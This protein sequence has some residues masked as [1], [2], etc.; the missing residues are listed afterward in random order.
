MKLKDRVILVTGASKGIGAAIAVEAAREGAGVVVNYLSDA[1]GTDNTVAAIKALGREALGIR[2]DVTK[3]EEIEKMLAEGIRSF[4]KVDLLVN[5]AGI[6]LWKP[7]LESDE[8]NWDC[9]LN[10]K[11]KVFF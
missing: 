5:N 4:G 10:A 2:A 6:A 3:K 11:L 7:F 9:T 1:S 8:D